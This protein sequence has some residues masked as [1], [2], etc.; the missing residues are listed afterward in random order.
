MLYSQDILDKYERILSI[1]LL[2]Y[3]INYLSFVDKDAGNIVGYYSGEIIF[4]ES[5]FKKLDLLLENYHDLINL[6]KLNKHNFQSLEDWEILEELENIYGQLLLTSNCSK[7]LRSSILKGEFNLGVNKDY[8]LRY[9]QTLEMLSKDINDIDPQNNWANL[10]LK[11]DL[12]EEDYTPEGG[13]LLKINFLKNKQIS[14]ITSVID[15]LDKEEKIKGIDIYQKITFEDEDLKILSYDDT[16][17]QTVD[18]LLKLKKE[19]NP[20]FPDDGYEKELIGG[21]INML[22][23]PVFFRQ[24]TS[25]FKKDDSIDSIALKTIRKEVDGFFMEFE[26]TSITNQLLT[27][28]IPMSQ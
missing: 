4:N 20:E 24:L 2:S 17:N 12:I 8:G 28:Q 11:N 27:Q 1:D 25:L 19:D 21:N 5:S 15:N 18:I 22:Q 3:L 6:I 7:F 14:E 23:F 9:Q 13:V 16:F 26:I 10:A